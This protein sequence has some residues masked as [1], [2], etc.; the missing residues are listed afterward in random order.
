[1]NWISV[2][3]VFSQDDQDDLEEELD[4]MMEEGDR[5]G[6]NLQTP[7]KEAASVVPA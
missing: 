6:G 1:M 7:S 4:K 2:N 5:S 3:S